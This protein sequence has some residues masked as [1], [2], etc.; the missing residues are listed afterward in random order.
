MLENIITLFS[1]INLFD[2]IGINW[3]SGLSQ[4]MTHD[5]FGGC[6]DSTLAEIAHKELEKILFTD[7]DY[8]L[9]QCPLPC[10]QI[11]YTL[12]TVNFHVT[13]ITNAA[14]MLGMT[15][16][17]FAVEKA[18][19]KLAYDVGDLLAQVGGTLGLTLG[20]SC[21]SCL[22]AVIDCLKKLM[23]HGWKK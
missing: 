19:E 23:D 21:L 12:N 13:S 18:I 10:R 5:A 9:S 7:N 2:G 17:N 16:E 1:S 4:F 20:F 14:F 8:W 6:Q 22:I 11:Y 3:F 15:Y